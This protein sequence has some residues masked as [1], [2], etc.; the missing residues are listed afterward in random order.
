MERERDFFFTDCI[1]DDDEARV[2]GSGKEKRKVTRFG[3]KKLLF[4]GGPA[5]TPRDSVERRGVRRGRSNGRRLVL[6]K[7][8]RAIYFFF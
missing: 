8:A 5:E 6:M 2:G 4:L 1:D 3:K 7:T